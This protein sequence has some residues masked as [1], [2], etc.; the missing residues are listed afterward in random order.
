MNV[1]YE[2]LIVYKETMR[3]M[4]RIDQ[5]G[6]QKEEQENAARVRRWK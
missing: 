6:N 5:N 2:Q 3:S 1:N 4:K